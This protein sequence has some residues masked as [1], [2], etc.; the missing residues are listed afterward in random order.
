MLATISSFLRKIHSIL[1][2]LFTGNTASFVTVGLSACENW[3]TN[4]F[5]VLIIQCPI[6]FPKCNYRTPKPPTFR[7]VYSEINTYGISVVAWLI[8][9][10]KVGACLRQI[11]Q[12]SQFI[13]WFIYTVL[14]PLF[15]QGS[16]CELKYTQ[17]FTFANRWVVINRQTD[18]DCVLVI[19]SRCPG[20]A[21]ESSLCSRLTV[22]GQDHHRN[23][24]WYSFAVIQSTSFICSNFLV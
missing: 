19:L 7:C 16:K 20:F 15:R 12:L 11:S 6:D 9:V 13:T 21:T 23:F 2:I 18:N 10:F 8:R 5:W 22:S 1:R 24:G 4:L 3:R 14:P 17:K